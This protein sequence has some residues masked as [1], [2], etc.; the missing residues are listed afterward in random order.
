[1][2]WA[3]LVSRRD[4]SDGGAGACARPTMPRSQDLAREQSQLVSSMRQ[5]CRRCGARGDTHL[6]VNNVIE[7]EL[8]AV[9]N[10]GR[11]VRANRIAAKI[12]AAGS[13]KA[14]ATSGSRQPRKKDSSSTGPIVAARTATFHP[15]TNCPGTS[16]DGKRESPRW[17]KAF[18]RTGRQIYICHSAAPSPET[19]RLGRRVES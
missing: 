5:R 1:M 15:T 11:L 2:R 4:D 6:A 17:P 14:R 9:E 13:P 16:R 3:F 12:T 7:E 8:D 10:R 18:R 19:N